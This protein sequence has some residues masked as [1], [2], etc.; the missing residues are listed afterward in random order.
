MDMWMYSRWAN[1]KNFHVSV[2]QENTVPRYVHSSISNVFIV[3]A[4]GTLKKKTTAENVWAHS[5]NIVM[6]MD[7]LEDEAEDSEFESQSST[8]N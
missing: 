4:K 3:K 8:T 1:K 2:V 5:L 6:A 7:K